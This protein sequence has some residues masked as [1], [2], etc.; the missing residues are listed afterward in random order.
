MRELRLP[1]ADAEQMFRRM[2]FNIMAENRDDHTKNISFLM[3][4]TGKWQLSPAYDM[5][6]AFDPA[7]KWIGAHQLSVNGKRTEIKKEDMLEVATKMNIK[8][9]LEIIEQVED[10]IGRWNEFA[11]IAEVGKDFMEKFKILFL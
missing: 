7:N 8:K 1:Y 5:T 2:V 9:P 3:D 10:S 11:K 4:K 6:Y